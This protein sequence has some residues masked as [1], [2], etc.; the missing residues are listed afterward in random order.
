MCY[1]TILLHAE[2]TVFR[3]LIYCYLA[4]AVQLIN[5]SGK[6]VL[7]IFLVTWQA[8]ETHAHVGNRSCRFTALLLMVPQGKKYTQVQK[9]FTRGICLPNYCIGCVLLC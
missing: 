6:G 8:T 5:L 1:F 7:I 4:F 9:M 3:C 2:I